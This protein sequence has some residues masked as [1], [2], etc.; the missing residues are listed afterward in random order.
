[1]PSRA[2]ALGGRKNARR[3]LL[4]YEDHDSRPEY[5][6]GTRAEAARYWEERVPT[7]DELA[8]H[9]IDSDFLESV[10]RDEERSTLKSRNRVLLWQTLWNEADAVVRGRH[11][12]ST[13]IQ[14][15]RTKLANADRKL[16]Q[17][18]SELA[19]QERFQHLGFIGALEAR[20]RQQHAKLI[21]FDAGIGP[22]SVEATLGGASPQ[23]AAEAVRV[24]K[25][26]RV[27]LCRALQ[28]SRNVKDRARRCMRR[29]ADMDSK[30]EATA[31]AT[32]RRQRRPPPAQN[33]RRRA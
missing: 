8:E 17:A 5:H 7:A 10:K 15:M 22:E 28:D 26:R 11:F 3:V 13:Q 30:Y 31:A 20:V 18:R 19:E 25:A 27:E 23:S 2:T 6:G 24:S 14:D 33:G 32:M 1:M 9:A 4:G 29:I 12:D 16:E 21:Q